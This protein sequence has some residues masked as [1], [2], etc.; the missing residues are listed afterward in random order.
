M[1]AGG[2]RPFTVAPAYG[3]AACLYLLYLP[4]AEFLLDDWGVIA[5]FEEARRGGA[6]GMLRVA[7]ALVD[8]TFHRQFRFQWL[9]FSMGYALVLVFG[10]AP[11]VL[12]AA[13]VLAHTACAVV[14]RQALEKLGVAPGA[15]FLSGLVFL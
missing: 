4:H 15:A 2:P 14:W 7:G 1:S 12:F 10:R 9:S 13:L 11:A 3:A 6:G 8:N 5:R